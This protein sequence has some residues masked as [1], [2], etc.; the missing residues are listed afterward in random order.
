MTSKLIH[1][2]CVRAFALP[3]MMMTA[4]TAAACDEFASRL[5]DRA[6]RPEIESLDG[7]LVGRTGLD[8]RD[9]H[10]VSVC[11][12]STGPTSNI[13]IVADLKC[14]TSGDAFIKTEIGDR[15]TALAEVRASDC[16]LLNVDVTTS[17]EIGKLLLNSFN[18]NGKARDAL[19][20]ALGRLC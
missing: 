20:Q 13:E 5:I 11:Y 16:Q 4:K 9:H 7:G 15:V 17:G 18:V 12:T 19:V 14:K 2:R 3:G 8:V 1:L 6:V 10:L